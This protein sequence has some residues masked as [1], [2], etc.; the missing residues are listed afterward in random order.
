[1][2]VRSLVSPK[3]ETFA[4]LQDDKLYTLE[5]EHTGY[6]EGAL[7][8]D[9]AYTAVWRLH[10]DA[11]HTLDHSETIGYLATPIHDN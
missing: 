7:I 10:G 3:G 11:I 4:Y 2:I 1:M 6:R 8:V 9:L 5:G